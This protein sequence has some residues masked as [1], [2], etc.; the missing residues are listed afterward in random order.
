[1]FSI[2]P[3]IQYKDLPSY[4]DLVESGANIS[5]PLVD[6]STKEF[7][8]HLNQ[9]WYNNVIDSTNCQTDNS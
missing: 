9:L 1:M 5:T 7:G 4:S 2:P 3:R 6:W 8:C